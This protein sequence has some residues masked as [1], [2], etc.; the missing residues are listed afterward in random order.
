MPKF[1]P[2]TQE[3][4]QTVYRSW[5]TK[6]DAEIA[7]A[8][9]RAEPE[10]RWIADYIKGSGYRLPKRVAK[11]SLKA[12]VVNAIQSLKQHKKAQIGG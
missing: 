9:G 12:T 10:V 4:V 7:L 3:E 5:K 6:T 1:K 2:F 8:I 11:N